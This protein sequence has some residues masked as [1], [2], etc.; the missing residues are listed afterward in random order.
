M[1]VAPTAGHALYLNANGTAKHGLLAGGSAASGGNAAGDGVHLVGGGSSTSSGGTAGVG[2]NIVGGAGSAST[3]GAGAGLSCAAGGTTTVSGN[4]GAKFTGTGNGN[5]MTPAH[6][7]TGL[8]LNATTTPL[9]LAK[10]TNI[11][12]FND[13]A[14]TAVVSSGAITTSGG[15]VSEVALVDTLTTYT[16]NTPQTGDAFARSAHLRGVRFG[17]RRG[18]QGRLA[19]RPHGRGKYQGRCLGGQWSRDVLSHCG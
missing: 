8:D 19:H 9:T 14:A 1:D 18:G 10:T 12:G 16:G 3:N 2:F 4:D 5:G 6:A 15:K 17:R 11:T 7:G 13:I